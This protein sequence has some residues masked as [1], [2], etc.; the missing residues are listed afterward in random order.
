MKLT[1][2]FMLL[3][4]VAA[5]LA[6]QVVAQSNAETKQEKQAARRAAKEG[7]EPGAAEET[8]EKKGNSGKKHEGKQAETAPIVYTYTAKYST[9][10]RRTRAPLSRL[11]RPM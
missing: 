4:G 8:G 2:L 10:V 11:S 3:S 6:P 1:N 7:K 5:V 9:T